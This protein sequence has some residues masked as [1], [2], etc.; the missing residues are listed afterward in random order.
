MGFSTIAAQQRKEAAE[1]LRSFL[2]YGLIGSVALHIGVLGFGVSNLL[3][4][5]TPLADEPIELTLVEPY[6]LEIEKPVE[7]AKEKSSNSSSQDNTP[8]KVVSAPSSIAIAQ[9][10]APSLP[11]VVIQ[12]QPKS[13]KNLQKKEVVENLKTPTPP[14]QTT[15][16]SPTPEIPKQPKPVVTTSPI[17]SARLALTSKPSVAVNQSPQDAKPNEKLTAQLRGIRDSRENQG[18]ATNK[19]GLSENLSGV[20]NGSNAPGGT[21]NRAGSGTG[22]G[23]RA[24]NGSGTGTGNGSGTGNRA[25]NGSGTGTG[26]GNGRDSTVATGSGAIR[27]GSDN[28]NGDSTDSAEGRLACR[29]CSKPKYPNSARRRGVE[30]TTKIKVDVNDK[31]NVTNVRVAESSGNSDLDAAAIRAARNWK[32][33]TPNGAR[34]GLSAK[35]DFAIEGSERSRQLRDRR[36]Q[37]TRRKRSSETQNATR[38]PATERTT[39]TTQPAATSLP[40]RTAPSTP[41][42]QRRVQP[43]SVRRLPS[44]SSGS[45]TR[46]HQSLRRQPLQPQPVRRLRSTA[47]GNQTRLRQSLRRQRQSPSQ[48]TSNSQT[49]LRQ[50]LRQL[51]QNPQPTVNPND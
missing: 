45:Q 2:A 5:V 21:G 3:D 39:A 1:T 32:F 18:I 8:S 4:R 9:G 41:R 24:G 28:K 12:K 13:F 22:T 47:S 49:K 30:G 27:R 38:T 40:R 50:S 48:T 26:T 15:A 20:G 6:T 25:G 14:K 33:N 35:V 23:N 46:L 10:F 7:E 42:R 51:Q 16:Q 44:T 36:R 37:A 31:G 29:D 43:Q 17:Q 19:T 34:E 11:S